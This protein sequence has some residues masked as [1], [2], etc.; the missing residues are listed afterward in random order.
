MP[1]LVFFDRCGAAQYS[2][3]AADCCKCHTEV[4]E[5]KLRKPYVHAPV[6]E[7][8]C[9]VC[10]VDP[11]VSRVGAAEKRG[12]RGLAAIKWVA[13]DFDMAKEHWF[14]LDPD[15]AGKTL[16]CRSEGLGNSMYEL[17]VQLPQELRGVNAIEN[18]KTPPEITNLQVKEVVKGMLLTATVVWDTDKPSDSTVLY[19][20]DRLDNRSPVDSRLKLKHEMR[21]SG[22]AAG[23]IYKVAS[24]SKDLFGNIGN[25]AEIS[26]STA[27]PLNGAGNDLL[28]DKAIQ[29][30][31]LVEQ[32]LFRAAGKFLLKVTANQPVTTQVGLAPKAAKKADAPVMSSAGLPAGHLPLADTYTI[33]TAVCLTC[34]PVTKGILSHPINVYP[35]N[36]MVI[37]DDYRTLPDG[38][39]SCMSCHEPHASEYEYRISRPTKKS[40]CL[41][42]HKNFG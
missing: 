2:V 22:L 35:K 1:T 8:R 27:A 9:A 18:Y 31:L 33:T 14:Q 21:I 3:Q 34:H 39:L 29:E 20:L 19:G 7:K 23:K 4:C 10:H 24:V 40:L 11:T 13:R 5:D 26:F 25:S 38:R 42:C 36:G 6:L 17:E 28:Q 37:P 12:K 32:E 16:V 30:T 41:G 15:L